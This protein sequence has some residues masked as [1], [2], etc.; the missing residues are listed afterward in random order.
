MKK[1]ILGIM[2]V[3]AL[4]SCGKSYSFVVDKFMKEYSPRI[5]EYNYFIQDDKYIIV[6]ITDKVKSPNGEVTY[7]YGMYFLD[8]NGNLLGEQLAYIKG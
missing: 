5:T 8:T 6:N 1:I 2:L 4:C 7:Y 3:L